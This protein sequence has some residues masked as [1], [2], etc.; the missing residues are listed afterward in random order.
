M[1]HYL[2][3]RILSYLMD[4]FQGTYE[5]YHKE[6][7]AFLI[8][9]MRRYNPKKVL[10]LA[11]KTEREL[12]RKEFPGIEIHSIGLEEAEDTENYYLHNLNEAY[13][14]PVKDFDM[15][16]ACEIIEHLKGNPKCFVR[17]MRKHGKYALVTTPNAF[18]MWYRISPLLG[19]KTPWELVARDPEDYM[20]HVY[21]YTIKDVESWGTVDYL[22][23]RNYFGLWVRDVKHWF[24][25]E[26]GKFFPESW[27]DGITVVFR[28][29]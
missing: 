23:V 21:E 10:L 1:E 5:E 4:W 25:R 3:N 7:Y 14:L 19:W 29:S 22:A 12:I 11:P 26:I 27:R 6:R 9:V 16:I 15:V 18:C 2:T 28:Q 20:G 17:N 8:K 24:F 13:D